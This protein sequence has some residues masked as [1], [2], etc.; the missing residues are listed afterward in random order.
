MDGRPHGKGK[1]KYDQG[2]VFVGEFAQGAQLRGVAYSHGKAKYTMEA[3]SWNKEL[4][5]DLVV[6]FPK[7]NKE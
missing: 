1:L 5:M 7:W 2:S 6:E 3:G 4:N